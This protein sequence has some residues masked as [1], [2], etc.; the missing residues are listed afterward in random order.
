MRSGGFDIAGQL[1]TQVL[2]AT[3]IYYQTLHRK[4]MKTRLRSRAFKSTLICVII[5]SCASPLI[6]QESD[7]VVDSPVQL[8]DSLISRSELNRLFRQPPVDGN[9]LRHRATPLRNNNSV[10]PPDVI[11]QQKVHWDSNYRPATWQEELPV[12]PVVAITTET[13]KKTEPESESDSKTEQAASIMGPMPSMELQ[14]FWGILDMLPEIS[15]GQLNQEIAKRR[16]AIDSSLGIDEAAKTERLRQLEIADNAAQQATQNVAGK[17][18]FQ[19][20][21]TKLNDS[22]EELRIESRKTSEPSPVDATQPVE[23]MQTVLRN[24]QAEL[25]LTNTNIWKIEKLIQERDERMARIP[26]ERAQSRSDVD[27]YHEEFVKRQA[28]G[29]EEIEVLLAFRARELAASTNVQLLDAESSW[30]DLSQE[31]LPLEKSIY[32]R[33]LQRLE[34]EVDSWNKAIADRIQAELEKQVQIA[35]TSAIQT[36]PALKEFS[37]ETTKLA[38]ARAELAEK[39]GALE[40]EKLKVKKQADEVRIQFENLDTSI[41]VAGKDESGDLL[42]QIHR[43]LIRPFEGMARIR[44]LESEKKLTRGTILKLRNEIARVS[45][46]QNFISNEL[47]IERDQRVADTTL[48]AMAEEAI[49]THRQQLFALVGDNEAYQSSITVVLPERKKLLKKI[50]ETREL[51]DTHA[52]WIQSAEPFNVALLSQSSEGAKEFFDYQ[53][54]CDLGGS[55]AFRVTHRP[56]EC[57]VGILGLLAAFIV[58]R[59]FKG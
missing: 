20:R 19:N 45:D 9:P 58:G 51:V 38:E 33:K 54:W 31:K 35:K 23:S 1:M 56:Y 28:A 53:Q 27:E 44:E 14:S 10:P 8:T 21:V 25:E 57:V 48:I 22:L 17:A 37:A 50:A 39:I 32:Q 15:V 24:L 18:E 59:R 5:I 36:H 26:E 3:R 34:L 11:P 47:K 43:T 6:A 40:S 7:V 42:I 30:Q 13:E 41:R 4:P 52:L 2:F 29:P 46:S 55:I 16:T 49:E 12:K